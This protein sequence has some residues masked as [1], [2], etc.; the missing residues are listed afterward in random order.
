MKVIE[1]IPTM[2]DNQISVLF[3]NA[4]DMILRKKKLEDAALVIK[5]IQKEWQL[6][7]NDFKKGSYKADS[8]EQGVLKTIGYKVGNEGLSKSK[9]HFLLDYIIEE[10]L[11]PVGSPAHMAEWGVPKSKTRYKKLHRVIRVL[12]SGA[13]S[14]G[15]MDKAAAEWEDDLGY[16]ETKWKDVVE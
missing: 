14:M 10:V 13:I 11:P 1:K 7:L 5:A 8:P 15:N 9:R 6:R 3:A 4:T 2:N 12:A 16:I